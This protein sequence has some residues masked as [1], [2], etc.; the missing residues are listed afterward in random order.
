MA[1][2][3]PLTDHEEIRRWA[4]ARGAQPTCVT[5]TGGKG[6]AGMIR[7]DFPG[8]SGAGKLQPI[9]WREWFSSFDRGNLALLVQDKTA[10]GQPSNFNKLVACETAEGRQQSRP[11][12]SGGS[13][14]RAAAGRS[15]SLSRSGTRSGGSKRT[16]STTRA[17]K[18]RGGTSGSRSRSA[19]K[20]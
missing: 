12:A 4:E 17:R 13:R 6:D 9:T 16:G 3:H 7:L 20:R 14:R 5:G 8:F 11:K 19:R 1:S 2:A 18:T 10:R 15:S